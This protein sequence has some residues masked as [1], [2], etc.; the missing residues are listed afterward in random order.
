M[1]LPKHLE[2][3]HSKARTVE[4]RVCGTEVK[5]KGPRALAMCPKH[6]EEHFANQRKARSNAKKKK[7]TTARRTKNR[8]VPA[9][10]APD[11]NPEVAPVDSLPPAPVETQTEVVEAPQEPVA[12]AQPSRNHKRGTFPEAVE[13]ITAREL[14]RE[15]Y[16]VGV[17]GNTGSG[18]TITLK[19]LLTYNRNQALTLIHDD[20]KLEPQYA[21][22]VAWSFR[23][24][25]DDAQTVVFR[26]DVF[27]STRVDPEY[28]SMVGVHVA[29]TTRQPVRVV[30]DEAKRAC[31]KGGMKITSETTIQIL[32]EGR[33]LGVSLLW[34]N[35]SP[36]VPREFVDQADAIV[37][38]RMGPRALNYLDE[39]LRFD[40]ELLEAVP[41][42]EVGEFV[43]YEDGRPWN[44]V[45]YTTPKPTAEF[46][47]GFRNEQAS[48][49]P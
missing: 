7:R 25:P 41:N 18:K 39:T 19:T 43:I 35:Q 47:H 10:P 30:L 49:T 21:G 15:G 12:P 17:L 13:I 42:L 44:G 37:L 1:P 16:R 14:K 8:K 9:V 3:I 38:H 2:G 33:M 11:K 22:H 34:S 36:V 40:R 20:T 27:K 48:P 29:K 23:E 6:R 45:I 24:A 28:V 5:I 46:D 32:T 4:C 31:T 26:G